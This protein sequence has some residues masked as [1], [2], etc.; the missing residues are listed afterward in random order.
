MV[1]AEAKP[2]NSSFTKALL[3]VSAENDLSFNI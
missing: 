1:E 2:N 3:V